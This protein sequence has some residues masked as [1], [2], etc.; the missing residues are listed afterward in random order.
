M[1]VLNQV[2]GLS[3]ATGGMPHTMKLV[4]SSS[5][6]LCLPDAC[7]KPSHSILSPST[8]PNLQYSTRTC[9][10]R[11]RRRRRQQRRQQPCYKSR[12]FATSKRYSNPAISSSPSSIRTQ[13]H[14]SR[15]LN[16]IAAKHTPPI[17]PQRRISL[18]HYTQQLH[19]SPHFQPPRQYCSSTCEG[20]FSHLANEQEKK[21]RRPNKIN[22][23]GGIEKEKNK[24]VNEV[25]NT[26]LCSGML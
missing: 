2:C 12:A 1:I 4:R 9:Q 23:V 15:V 18:K 8:E 20:P 10:R 26:I 5:S 3:R 7:L 24:N 16:T 25:R 21:S 22:R 13:P 19:S 14:F 6:C 11:R 17:S